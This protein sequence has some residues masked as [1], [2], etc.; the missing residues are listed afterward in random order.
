MNL[1][2]ARFMSM[3][4]L[5]L[6]AAFF[7]A[8]GGLVP[9][10]MVVT[11]DAGFENGG[12]IQDGNS[13]P[14]SDTRTV[15]GTAGATITEVSVRVNLSGGYNGDLYGYLSHNGV[16]VPL[17]NRVGVGSAN[18][19][20]YGDAGLNVT[21]TDGAANN[22]H[23][24]QAVE[25]YS[26]TGGSAWQPDGRTLNPVTSLPADFDAS[27]AT[28][29]GAFSGMNPNGD[30]SFV[31]ADVSSGGGQPMVV[32]WGLDIAAAGWEVSVVPEPALGVFAIVSLALVQGGRVWWSRRL[33]RKIPGSYGS[34]SRIG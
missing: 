25:G 13:S 26:I 9:A 34:G 14:W 7:L 6:L 11:Y 27:G 20:G 23:F 3:N 24:Y 10:A 19:F 5:T 33:A 18:A 28:S 4:K 15:S 29:L 1:F 16:M 22:I 21:F 12:T 32:S 17:L 31:L 30:W 2:Q 8:A